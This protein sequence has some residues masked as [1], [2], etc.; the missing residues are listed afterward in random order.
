MEV[1]LR[2]TFILNKNVSKESPN[3]E[4]EEICV[5]KENVG[6][7][8]RS[9]LQEGLPSKRELNCKIYVQPDSTPPHRAMFSTL[10]A[11]LLVNEH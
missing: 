2:S 7:V 4:D 1:Q 8:F 3:K 11:E 6:R 5:L 9:V 10:P